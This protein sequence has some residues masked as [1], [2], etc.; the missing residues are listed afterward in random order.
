MQ[1]FPS[2]GSVG[3]PLRFWLD[4][5]NTEA[6]RYKYGR[7]VEAFLEFVGLDARQVLELRQ[8]D[9]Q[10]GDLV[11]QRRFENL[12]RRFLR[13]LE[14]KNLS[15]SNRKGQN[16]GL[17]SFFSFYDMPLLMRRSDAP[18]GEPE[19]EV[20]AF[21]RKEIRVLLLQTC[22]AVLCSCS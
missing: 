4:G 12:L 3:D 19:A 16:S 17:K 21:T 9:L 15:I 6:T 1:S 13:D 11:R 8:E 20:R 18:K 14:R 10:S 22:S 5:L 7:G 2:L